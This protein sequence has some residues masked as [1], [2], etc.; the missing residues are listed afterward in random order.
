MN[1]FE[2]L[3][4]GSIPA[5]STMKI[6]TIISSILF[7]IRSRNGMVLFS[8]SR[9]AHFRKDGYPHPMYRSIETSNEAIDYFNRV[10]KM[11]S[12]IYRC[13]ECGNYHIKFK[14][15]NEKSLGSKNKVQKSSV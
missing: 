11:S 4:A 1:G 15:N 10:M 13:G 12:V 5:G 14:H 6:H 8:L 2:P 7:N 3:D 9:L